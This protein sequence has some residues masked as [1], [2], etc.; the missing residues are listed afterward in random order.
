[1]PIQLTCENCKKSLNVRDE[2]AGKRV[3]CPQCQT[4]VT[5]PAGEAADAWRL[6]TEDG[7]T[8]GPVPRAELDGWAKEGR[9]TASCQVLREGDEQWRWAAD[10][11]PYLAGEQSATSPQTSP[12]GGAAA[13]SPSPASPAAAPAGGSGGFDFSALDPAAQQPQQQPGPFD[14]AGSEKSGG[15]APALEFGDDAGRGGRKGR[16]RGGKPAATTAAPSSSSVNLSEQPGYPPGVQPST[17]SPSS[18]S[19]IKSAGRMQRLTKVGVLSF[20]KVMGASG[21]LIGLVIGIPYGLIVVLLGVAGAASEGGGMFGAMG[22][23]GGLLMMVIIPIFYG[24]ASF[25]FGL[26]YALIIN[27]VL[28]VTGGLEIELQ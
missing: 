25:V 26:I 15:A 20:A 19:R 4:V 8:Y 6:Q 27:L 11:Y 24:I 28:G 9:V 18:K 23:L 5:V 13:P 3:K 14:F 22:I 16:S 7:E 2:L 21:A 12:G 10:V 17:L 1:M